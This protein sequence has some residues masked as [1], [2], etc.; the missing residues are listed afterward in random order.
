MKW[1]TSP[2]RSTR[3]PGPCHCESAV[4]NGDGVLRPGMFGTLTLQAAQQS[5]V[6]VPVS[7]VQS[8]DGREI[9]FVQGDHERT[10]EARTVS[11]GRESDGAYP[12]LDGLS[13]GEVVV[14]DGAFILKSELVRSQLADGCVGE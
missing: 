14:V 13:G 9:V 1:T 12:V 8:L 11:L 10:F 5:A 3:R 4:A 2:C 6:T 7:A